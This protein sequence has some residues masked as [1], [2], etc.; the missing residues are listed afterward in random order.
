MFS[1]ATRRGTAATA[2]AARLASG[3]TGVTYR[4]QQTSV[5]WH[6]ATA[7]TCAEGAH[8]QN[9]AYNPTGYRPLLRSLR[10]CTTCSSEPGTRALAFL[11]ACSV[12]WKAA[13][14]VSSVNSAC[15]LL[16]KVVLSITDSCAAAAFAAWRSARCSSCRVMHGMCFGLRCL[17]D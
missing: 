5:A 4:A 11:L 8:L 13:L 1:R 16:A 3:S 9:Q 15:C 17:D 6:H 10:A 12:S 14:T 2:A 7:S